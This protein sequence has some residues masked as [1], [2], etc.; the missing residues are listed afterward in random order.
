VTDEYFGTR[1][2]DPYRWM[3]SMDAETVDWMKAQ[4]RYTRGLL[5]SIPGRAAY[6]ERLS[7]FTGAFGLAK[8]YQ[9]YAGRSFYLY[10]APGSDDF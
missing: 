9:A 1:I 10:R 8:S 6:L 2:V 4:G 3:E 5:D 7:A